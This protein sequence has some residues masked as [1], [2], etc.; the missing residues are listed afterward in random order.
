MEDD[1][2]QYHLLMRKATERF[3]KALKKLAEREK[4]DMVAEVGAVE[5]KG[6]VKRDIPDVTKELIKLVT[7]D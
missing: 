7:R 4:Y 2:P 3:T 1:D 5:S 6:D